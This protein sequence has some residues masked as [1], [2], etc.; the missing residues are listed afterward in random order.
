MP[1]LN[2]VRRATAPPVTPAMRHEDLPMFV[3]IQTPLITA[4][5]CEYF[6]NMPDRMISPDASP[7]FCPLLVRRP[8]LAYPRIV[9][10]ALIAVKPSVWPPHETIQAFVRILV[11]KSIEENFWRPI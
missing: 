4:A 10:D 11:A 9:E 8:G 3:V 7:Q 2:D 6:E 5:S 1:P